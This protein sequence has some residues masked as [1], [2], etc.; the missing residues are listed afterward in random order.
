MKDIEAL[1]AHA[2]GWIC[3]A[4]AVAIEPRMNTD[5][6][7]I[8][9]VANNNAGDGNKPVIWL[10]WYYLYFRYVHFCRGVGLLFYQP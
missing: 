4:V 8:Q 9:G 7:E 2:L 3:D 10:D 5:R 1:T 6:A